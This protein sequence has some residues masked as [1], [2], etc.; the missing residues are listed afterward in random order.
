MKLKNVAKYFDRLVFQDAYQPATTFKGQFDVYDDS[1]RDGLTIER[2]IVSVA[3]EVVV[4]T[5]KTVTADGVTWMLG[6]VAR[7]YYKNEAIRHKYVAHL[8]Q[9]LATV[10]TFEETLTSAAGLSAYASRVWVKGSKEIEES[11][12]VVD[13]FNIYF[14][15]DEP[16]VEGMLIN[17][18]GRFH[19]VRS[20]Y[21]S[22]GGFLVALVDELAEPVVVT[23]TTVKRTYRPLTDTFQEVPTSTTALRIRWQ[24]HFKYPNKASETYKPGD[25]VLVTLKS[26]T[27]PKAGDK[28]VLSGENYCVISV[29]DEGTVWSMHIR[30]D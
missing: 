9:G 4:P 24:S 26:S 7:D 5:R 23:C 13:V 15:P 16:V 29:L 30:N 1:K 10:R 3:P 18:S 17:L 2:R 20:V 21:P 14:A 19:L 27:T 28:V 25:D 11:S 8:A 12:D 22:A 6:D